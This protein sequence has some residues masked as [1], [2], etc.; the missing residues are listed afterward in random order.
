VRTPLIVKL[1]FIYKNTGYG[2]KGLYLDHDKMKQFLI[3]SED[4]LTRLTR[5]FNYGKF[6]IKIPLSL[7]RLNKYSLAIEYK[8]L[9]EEGRFKNQ[10][11]LARAFGVSRAWITKV[12]NILKED[13]L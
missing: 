11:E 8:N 7:L 10:A 1:P 13:N 4:C 9:I 6:K 12:M 2:K 5:T 3:V